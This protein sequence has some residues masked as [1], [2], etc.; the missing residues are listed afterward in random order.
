MKTYLLH[1]MGG[2]PADWA[3][4]Q[5]YFPA[6]AIALPAQA[7]F[8]ALVNALRDRFAQEKAP[9]GLAGYSLGGRVAIALSAALLQAESPPA[10][11]ALLGAGLG[12]AQEEERQ[13]RKTA[14]QAWADLLRRDPALFWQKWYDQPLFAGFRALPPAA[15]EDWLTTRRAENPET[16]ARQWEA[17]GPAQ[18]P[19]LKPVLDDIAQSSI[20]CLYLAGERDTKYK[21]LAHSLAKEGMRTLLIPGAGHLLPLEAP[22]AVGEAL[23]NFFNGN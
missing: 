10:R 23:R 4:V 22:Q 11:L 12:F 1:G 5:E 9:Y 16:L 8:A 13:I 20:R 6:E 7:S 17:W 15:Q 21:S 18:H 2:S 3:G 19:Y 14:D